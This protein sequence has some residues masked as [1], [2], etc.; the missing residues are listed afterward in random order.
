MR[1]AQVCHLYHPHF[2]G[3]QTHVRELS[4]RLQERGWEVEVFTT[5]PTWSLPRKEWVDGIRVTRFPSLAPQDSFHLSRPFQRYLEH[6]D[7]VHAHNYHSFP[8]LWASRSEHFVFTPHYHG[9]SPSVVRNLLLRLYKPLG[10]LSFRRAEK[11]I[12]VSNHELKLVKKTFKVPAAKLVHI[13]NGVEEF[14]TDRIEKRKEKTLLFVGRLQKYKGVQHILHALQE[15]PDYSLWVI[16]SGNYEKQLKKLALELG[17]QKRVTWLKNLPKPEMIKRYRQASLFINLSP[18]EA[19]GITTAEALACATPCIVSEYGGL[20]EFID[21]KTCFGAKPK[22]LVKTIE[23]APEPGF[24]RELPGWDEVAE[25]T[26]KLY[27]SIL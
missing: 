8:A 20:A 4:K 13:P 23:K 6:F 1:V 11:I 24:K 3:I 12:C 5:D 26:S 7:I 16:G 18:F 19:Y 25:K 9:G 17:V 22:T 2:G 27:K 14:K 21:N 15:L 10:A